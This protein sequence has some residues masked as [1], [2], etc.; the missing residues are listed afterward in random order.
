MNKEASSPTVGNDKESLG[1]KDSCMSYNPKDHRGP[2]QETL[3][4]IQVHAGH[5]IETLLR[6]S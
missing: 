5:R 6:P 4:N 2:S 1:I 3:K